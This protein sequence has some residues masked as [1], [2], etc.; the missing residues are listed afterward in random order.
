MSVTQRPGSG[1]APNESS[2]EPAWK[3]VPSW[4]LVG[5]NDRIIPQ[6]LQVSMAERAHAHIE[7]VRSSHAVTVSHPEAVTRI[8]EEAARTVH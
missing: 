2:G 8:I 4:A 1:T 5:T 7:K 3:T 6:K